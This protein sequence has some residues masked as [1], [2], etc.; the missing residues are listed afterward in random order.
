MRSWVGDQVVK[1]GARRTSGKVQIKR[2][3]RTSTP[4]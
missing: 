2:A 1:T 4:T 3:M